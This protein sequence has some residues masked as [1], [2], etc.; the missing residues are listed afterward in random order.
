MHGCHTSSTNYL[1]LTKPLV[2]L[3]AVCITTQK[4]NDLGERPARKKA[5]QCRKH[6][7]VNNLNPLVRINATKPTMNRQSSTGQAGNERMTFGGGNPKHPCNRC[8]GY[9]AYRC[10]GQ[11]N[12]C[13]MGITAKIHHTAY[14]IC[15]RSRNK[16]HTDK[17][18]EVT[19][20]T[21]D[22][23]RVHVDCT[24]TNRFSDCICG[25]GCAIHKNGAQHQKHNYC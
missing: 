21:H 6:K 22:N 4:R 10:G 24:G 19:Y 2:C 7:A 20:D 1:H 5:E 15:D 13:S 18:N 9:N 3:Y 16:R 25:V 11:R 14:G 23:R 17:A 12:Q 8:P